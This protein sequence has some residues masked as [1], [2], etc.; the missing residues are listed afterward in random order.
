ME[1][2]HLLCPM[3]SLRDRRTGRPFCTIRYIY[4]HS[5]LFDV[6]ACLCIGVQIFRSSVNPDTS[7]FPDQSGFPVELPHLNG[8]HV[9]GVADY[10]GFQNCPDFC[11]PNGTD[12]VLCTMCFE[13]E[14][15]IV[16]GE[17]NFAWLWEFNTNEF[18]STCWTAN[19]SR[20]M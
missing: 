7:S 2:S 15:D 5:T 6:Y 10:R 14:D 8:E 4:Y 11:G 19:V 3:S 9:S 1:L 20:G 17:Y 16:E 13:L 18:Y 12:Q